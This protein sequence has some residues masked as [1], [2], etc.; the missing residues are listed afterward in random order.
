MKKVVLRCKGGK[1]AVTALV[2]AVNKAV[3]GDQ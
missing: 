2:D 3:L 1:K